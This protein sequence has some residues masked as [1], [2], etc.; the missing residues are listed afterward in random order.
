MWVCA[1]TCMCYDGKIWFIKIIFFRFFCVAYAN[2]AE[3]SF[4]CLWC[5]LVWKDTALSF[6]FLYPATHSGP[7]VTCT[8]VPQILM[9]L[10]DLNEICHGRGVLVLNVI[11]RAW[12]FLFL[13][14]APWAVVLGCSTPE[15][16]MRHWDTDRWRRTPWEIPRTGSPG[17]FSLPA[18]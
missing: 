16:H 10:A 14:S 3:N 13:V 5:P 11:S 7:D 1:W 17:N 18:S 12:K 6:P 8:S 4:C 2:W 15:S 9:A